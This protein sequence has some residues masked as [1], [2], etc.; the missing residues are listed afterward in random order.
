MARTV[1]SHVW[2]LFGVPSTDTRFDRSHKLSL[3]SLSPD[4]ILGSAPN[5]SRAYGAQGSGRSWRSATI[6]SA[7]SSSRPTTSRSVRV[8]SQ[9]A[10][11]EQLAVPPKLVGGLVQD[12]LAVGEDIAAVGHL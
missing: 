10:G 2:K 12:D 8:L 4:A 7:S 6:A 9:V 5:A 1:L 3:A 11:D